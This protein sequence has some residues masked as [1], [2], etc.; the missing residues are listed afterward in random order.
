MGTKVRVLSMNEDLPFRIKFRNKFPRTAYLIAMI[1][2]YTDK[3]FPRCNFEGKCDNLA[4]AE[5]Y[6]YRDR[7]M[8]EETGEVYSTPFIF[9]GGWSYLCLKHFIY[10][11][12]RGDK[13]MWCGADKCEELEEDDD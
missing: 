7:D 5:V 11:K 8:D 9:E 6:P 12:L 4:F 2:H 1:I 10:C 3:D 13:F